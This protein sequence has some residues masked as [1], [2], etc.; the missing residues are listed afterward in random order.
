MF[1]SQLA[2]VDQVND[3]LEFPTRMPLTELCQLYVRESYSVIAE[4][5]L[6]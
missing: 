4:Q 3:W 6:S 1:F 5:A 2:T